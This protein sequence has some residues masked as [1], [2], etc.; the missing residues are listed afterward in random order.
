[1]TPMRRIAFALLLG[2]LPFAHAHADSCGAMNSNNV[3][4][5]FADAS[6][7]CSNATTTGCT[8]GDPIMFTASAF[9]YQ[10]NCATHTFTWDFG[11]GTPNVTDSMAPAHVYSMI[12]FFTVTLT[13]SNPTE[14][15]TLSQLLPIGPIEGPP[16]IIR[17]NAQRVSGFDFVFTPDPTVA[18]FANEVEWDF[19]DGTVI[20]TQASSVM[21]HGYVNPGTYRVTLRVNRTFTYSSDVAVVT[22]QRAVRH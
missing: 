7:R 12:G 20:P 19:G 17:F 13:I 4:I 5:S 21:F 15:L 10:F 18:H 22:R 1:M 6:A 14:T 2:C 8:V 3:F 9:G 11:D 16:L